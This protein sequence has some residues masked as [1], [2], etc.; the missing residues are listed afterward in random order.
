VENSI[1]SFTRVAGL[2]FLA[3]CASGPQTVR[4]DG[5]FAGAAAPQLAF[6]TF[7]KAANEKDIQAMGTVF[8]TKAG[9]ARETM[10]RTELEKRL[11]ILSCYFAHDTARTLGED[12]GVEG[13][14]E[15]RVELKKG[16]LTRQT[17]FFTIQG[18]GKRWYVDNIDIAAVRDF[19]GNPGTGRS[20]R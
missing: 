18:P 15:L 1:V 11:I 3:A 10:D 19:C 14:R 2:V 9:P 6:D 5:S 12:R 4:N 17:T 13:H 16:N 8:G 7:L 20:G